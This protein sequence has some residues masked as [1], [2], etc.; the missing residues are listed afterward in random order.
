MFHSA[1][2]LDC[3]IVSHKCSC[4]RCRDIAD[5]SSPAR[6]RSKRADRPAEAA[7]DTE[8]AVFGSDCTSENLNPP[9]ATVTSEKPTTVAEY[10]QSNT[11]P[12]LRV[13]RDM[14]IPYNLISE[15]TATEVPE[16]EKAASTEGEKKGAGKQRTGKTGSRKEADEQPSV[17]QAQ[18]AETAAPAASVDQPG[19]DKHKGKGRGGKGPGRGKGRGRGKGKPTKADKKEIAGDLKISPPFTLCHRWKPVHQAQCYM[20]GHVEGQIDK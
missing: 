13:P 1:P 8:T 14:V 7:S 6:K 9:A 12:D 17:G 16:L 10:V 11:F 19:R 18:P 3:S 5:I 2:N 4:E 20:M 15:K